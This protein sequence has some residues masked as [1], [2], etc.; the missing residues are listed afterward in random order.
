MTPPRIRGLVDRL[1]KS[2]RMEFYDK[3]HRSERKAQTLEA[4]ME[5]LKAFAV[6]ARSN[7]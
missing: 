3:E 6:V 2:V 1:E 5:I 7:K 4:K